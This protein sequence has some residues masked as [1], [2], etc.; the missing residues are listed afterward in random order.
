MNVVITNEN[1]NSPF[2]FKFPSEDTLIVTENFEST[3]QSVFQFVA[4]DN[5]DADK[6]VYSIREE[7]P[8][9]GKFFFLQI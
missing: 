7:K 6:I 5:D 8:L 2:W 1:D 3:T 4:K 9:T